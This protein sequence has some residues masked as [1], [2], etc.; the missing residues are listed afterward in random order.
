[1]IKET[2]LS[3]TRRLA[4]ETITPKFVD[5]EV[6]QTTAIFNGHRSLPFSLCQDRT[7]DGERKT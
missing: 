4:S 1:M 3:Q 5:L 2:N 6:Q 7:P